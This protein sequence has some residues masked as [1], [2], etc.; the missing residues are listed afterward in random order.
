VTDL[1]GNELPNKMTWI[2][3]FDVVQGDII[4]FTESVFIGQ[5][6]HPRKIGDRRLIAK[7]VSESYGKSK[8]QHTFTLE[9]LKSD[10][11]EAI[12]KQIKRK[13][14]NIYR[15]GVER[16]E[17]MDESLRKQVC[18]EKHERGHKARQA[19]EYR[20]TGERRF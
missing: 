19:R 12:G 9:I 17:W 10:G 3:T 14:R 4:R 13:G 5:R 20:I 1:L 15:N 6:N 7:V 18:D 16:L 8:Q 2:P 11:A